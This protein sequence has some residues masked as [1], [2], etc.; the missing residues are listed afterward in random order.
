MGRVNSGLDQLDPRQAQLLTAWL[1]ELEV[2]DDHSWGLVGTTVL[3]LRSRGRR[4]IVK[5]GGDGDHHLAREI[6]AHRQW[7]GPWTSL[8][9]A[10]SLVR[11]DEDARLLLATYLPGELVEGTSHEHSADAYCQAGDL[12]AR[13]HGQVAVLDDGEFESRQ[14]FETLRWL[15]GPHRIAPDTA[16]LLTGVVEDWPTP[17]STVVPTHGDWQPRNWIVHDGSVGIIDFGRAALRP[18]STDFG[19]LAVQQFLA[20]PDLEQ[21]FLQGYGT[22]PREPGSWARLQVREAV[23]TAAWA[24]KVGD[25]A[26]EQQ[27][28]RMIAEAVRRL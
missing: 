18:A 25:E 2:V 13:F 20:H 9:R 14:K 15:S 10:P 1:P 7:L 3:E 21:A 12:L 8:G 23:G 26:F 19:R 6:T 22:D 27:G 5:G 4:Y 16:A 17:P 11:A 24:Y 28:H